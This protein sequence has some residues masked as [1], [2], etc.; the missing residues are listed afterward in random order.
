MTLIFDN[1]YDALGERF[2]ASLYPDPL[3]NPRAVIFNDD[4]LETLG[5]KQYGL[6]DL[7]SFFSGNSVPEGAAPLAMVYAGHQFGGYSPQLGD[8]RGILIGQIRNKKGTLIDLHLKGAGK[9]PFSRMGDG[10][11]VLR[12]CIREFLASEAL[13]HLGI[14]STRALAVTTSNEPVQRET[15]E[16]ASMLMRFS[17]SHI[18]FGSFEYF[19][20]TEQFDELRQLC[21][22]TLE[23]HFP[24]IVQNETK[25]DDFLCAVA[26][27]TGSLIAQWQAFGFAHG[28]MN[29]DNMSIIGQTF[30]Y[31]PYGF[32]EKFD[33]YYICN[34][35]DDRGRYAFNRQP[36]IGHWNCQA[37]AQALSSL[38]T[39]VAAKNMLQTYQ[40]TF[41]KRYHALMCRKLGLMETIEGDKDLYED[42]LDLMEGYGIDYTIFFRSLSQ[43]HQND[44]V[45]K[46]T[47]IKSCADDFA[48]WFKRYN[49]RLA[50]ESLDDNDRHEVMKK[51]NPKYILRNYLAQLAIQNSEN[52]DHSDLHRLYTVLKNPYDEQPEFESYARET[53]PWGQHLQIS[54][55]S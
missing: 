15:I 50:L 40:D 21:D 9:T 22:Y 49:E 16:N 20:Y 38:T 53:P 36:L 46:I 51:I 33:P 31:G 26:E 28:V 41:I 43:Y 34:H 35:S 24:Q 39:S 12:S 4:A 6:D 29:T 10:R 44:D 30:D 54:C 47:I 32:M 14:P 37:L 5:L 27:K 17:E 7:L 11:A 3:P 48:P 1:R 52:G 23:N 42:L 13:H 18:R 2:Y 45:G 25:Y 8:G 19:A 55:S